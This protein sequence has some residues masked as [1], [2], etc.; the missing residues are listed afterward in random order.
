M[1][2]PLHIPEPVRLAIEAHVRER[3][4]EVDKRYWSAAE[5]EDTYT[6]HLGALLGSSERKV[7]VNGQPWYWSIEYTKFR[8]R[9][10]DATEK[11]I[12]AD[13]IFEIRVRGIEVEGRKSLL[14]QSKMGTPVGSE[15]RIQA[16]ALSNWREAA[17]FLSYQPEGIKAFSI[18]EIIGDGTASG[19]TFDDF[20]LGSYLACRAGDSDLLY[21]AKARTLQWRDEQGLRVAVRFP[22]PRRL[23]VQILSPSHRTRSSTIITPKEITEHRMDSTPED[24][25]GLGAQFSTSELK[26]AKRKAALLCHPDRMPNLA[27]DLKAAMNRRM[28]EINVACEVLKGKVSRKH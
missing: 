16:L 11:V 4:S 26:R 20:F 28:A 17:V 9:G 25:L 8:G 12:G 18:D 27:D 6:G 7:L 13:G 22:I 5:D 15:A 3:L 10:K 24:R 14:F 19:T 23:R 1:R 2:R 21:D